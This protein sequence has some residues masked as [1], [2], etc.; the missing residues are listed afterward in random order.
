MSDGLKYFIQTP[1]LRQIG[2]RRL[3]RLLSAFESALKASNLQLPQPDAANDDFFADLANAFSCVEHLPARLGKALF[4]LENAASPENDRRLWSAISQ[5]LPGVSVSIDCALD[6][7]LELW[8]VAPNEFSQFP[9]IEPLIDT[10]EH[11]LKTKHPHSEIEAATAPTPHPCN[12]VTIQPCND[13][14]D[15]KT[16]PRL[17]QLTPAQYDRIRPAEAIRLGI[18]LETLDAEVARCRLVTDYDAQARAV[19][20][21]LIEPWPE[22]VNGA[23]VLHQVADRFV[24]RVVL[25]PGAS[26][27]LAL[28][29][30]HA[31][32]FRAFLH[33]PRLNLTS[34][35]SECGKTTTVDL[36]AALTPRALRTENLTA[37]VLFRLVAQHQPTLL[38][39]EVDSYLLYTEELRGLLN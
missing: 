22:P 38:L 23:E 33:T 27:A 5:R 8:F 17:A 20:L 28:W 16:F 14:N 39:D 4:T 21:T 2:H 31:H 25:P 7:A 24:L 13:S 30:A 37:P 6:R 3:A 32:A 15:S 12:D 9:P 35:K 19:K 26:H 34:V 1:I 36:I 10:N 29:P 11:E 18:R